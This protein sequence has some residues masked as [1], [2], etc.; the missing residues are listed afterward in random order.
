MIEYYGAGSDSLVDELIANK[1][2]QGMFRRH[3]EL[4]HRE[5]A[6][7]Y[8][9]IVDMA[10]S[11]TDAVQQVGTLMGHM[12]VS[13][14]EAKSY[15]EMVPGMTSLQLPGVCAP[16][17][18]AQHA[19][20]AGSAGAATGAQ[21]DKD[22]GKKGKKDKRKDGQ[23]GK[24]DKDAQKPAPKKRAKNAKGARTCPSVTI[25]GATSALEH[26]S[27]WM[28]FLLPDIKAL[29]GICVQLK[30]FRSQNHVLQSL[31]QATETLEK[32]Y[33]AHRL[34]MHRNKHVCVCVC[35]VCASLTHVHICT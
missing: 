18:P 16:A 27:E 12:E 23:D 2:A 5:D 7:M 22:D 24:D 6:V 15:A 10:R 8:L 33:E 35:S 30:A 9:C 11:T 25:E 28:A 3:P 4:P 32:A 19:V 21:G 29:H 31:V 13:G 26:A 1:K 17:P 14:D 20:A 34:S